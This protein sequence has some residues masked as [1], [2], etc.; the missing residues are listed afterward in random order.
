MTRD[1]AHP[2]ST[3]NAS[4][5]DRL[6]MGPRTQ[7]GLDAPPHTVGRALAIGTEVTETV[8]V[9]NENYRRRVPAFVA[10]RP[11]SPPPQPIVSRRHSTIVEW[12]TRG[13][14]RLMSPSPGLGGQDL[15]QAAP[16]QRSSGMVA[17]RR[18]TSTA[19]KQNE[20]S[21]SLR[22]TDLYAP[23][24]TVTVLL[25]YDGREQRGGTPS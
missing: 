5:D 17:A 2:G 22:L 13:G 16:G 21:S 15:F 24:P 6:A 25:H 18:P 10:S 9:T 1:S 23:A 19:G 7:R 11:S 4:R 12:P 20:W 8:N 3:P 14:L